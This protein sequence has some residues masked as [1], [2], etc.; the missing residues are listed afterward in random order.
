MTRITAYQAK[1]K[2]L[3][4]SEETAALENIYRAI[5]KECTS[6]YSTKEEQFIKVDEKDMSD[7]IIR[8]LKL[9][10]YQITYKPGNDAYYIIQWMNTKMN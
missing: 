3:I 8:D 6:K 9:D 2:F 5:E 1:Q 10:G 7:L 4:I